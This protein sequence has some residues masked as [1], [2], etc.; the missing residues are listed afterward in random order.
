MSFDELYVFNGRL[1]R[2]EWK[3]VGKKEMYIPY[4]ANKVFTASNA[5]ALLAPIT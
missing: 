4:N 5:E 2:F 1:D 3:L